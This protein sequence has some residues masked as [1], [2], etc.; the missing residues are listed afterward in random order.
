MST[1]ERPR[2]GIVGLGIMGSAYARNL[3]EGG[4]DVV[5][6][7]VAPA[8]QA[9]L[10]AMGGTV[11][12]SPGDVAAQADVILIALASVDALKAVCGGP[13]GLVH[14]IRP[15]VPVVEM[16]TFPLY[17]KDYCRD[18]FEA[19]GNP[20]LDCPVSGTGAQAAVR[21]LV[22]YAS[23]EEAVVERLRPMFDGFARS[24]RY[25]GPFGSGTKLKFVANLLVTI[26]NLSTAE[27]VLMAHRSGL[28]LKMMFEAIRDGAGNSRMFEVRA[29]MMFEECY[30]PAGMKFEV[31]MKDL[32]LISDFARD[33]RVPTPLLAAS[34]PFY[35]AAL[36][37]G[38]H[39]DDT[40]G[41]YSV[42]K[43]MSAPRG[44]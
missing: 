41:L 42:L 19:K 17:A 33:M 28:D 3:R 7:D 15:G 44:E 24:T 43:E 40:A 6:F 2:V 32:D 36:G 16:S 29:P 23:G 5:G 12:A 27:A 22:L 4:F 38:R 39:A 14:T 10:A 11:A 37:A 1:P 20:V 30:Q 13:E 8:A 25:V 35:V 34:I 9:A 21:D 31:Y 26:H 18:L